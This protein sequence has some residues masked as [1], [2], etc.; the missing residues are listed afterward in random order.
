MALEDTHEAWLEDAVATIIGL[1]HVL[2]ELTA[3]DLS[4]A[5]RRPPHSNLPGIAFTTAKR[6]G[7]IEPTGYQT[8]SAPSRKHGVQRVWKRKVNEGFTL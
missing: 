1:S 3:D 8:S 7:H 4:H 6:A 2:P 5:M